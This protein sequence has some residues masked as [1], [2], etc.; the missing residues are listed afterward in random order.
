MLVFAAGL[1]V[2]G[3]TRGVLGE[4]SSTEPSPGRHT[5][6]APAAVTSGGPVIRM[7]G[8]HP[9]SYTMPAR[10]VALTFDDGPDPTW[11]PKILA[12]LRHYGVPGTFFLVGAHVASNPGL[13][14][15]ELRDGDEIGSHT[16]T[17]ANLAT[18]GWREAFELTLTQNA[19]AGTVGVRTRLLRMPYSSEPDALAGHQPGRR[20]R[21]PVRLT[22]AASG[23]RRA[24][25]GRGAGRPRCWGHASRRRARLRQLLKS[26]RM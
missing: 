22:S 6:A 5:V 24:G 25:A 26:S 2:E 1:M 4:N 19:L 11:T 23:G 21:R 3:Y 10:T 9:R 7:A 20:L 8:S 14:R 15:E 12:V 16:Y 17:H 13:A 18:A